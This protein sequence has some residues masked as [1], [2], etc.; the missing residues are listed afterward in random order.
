M[1]MFQNQFQNPWAWMQMM[2][3]YGNYSWQTSNQQKP[4]QQQMQNQNLGNY[5][6]NNLKPL[7]QAWGQQTQPVQQQQSSPQIQ[8]NKSQQQTRPVQF[9]MQQQKPMMNKF[10]DTVQ[11]RSF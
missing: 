10:G 9:A 3:Q 8:G 7:N 6:F 11:A 5:N 1:D 4:Q 2:P